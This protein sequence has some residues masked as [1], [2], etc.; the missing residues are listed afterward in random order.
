MINGLS[1]R[2]GSG[3]SYEAVVTHIL[4]ALKQGRKIVTNIPLNV[5]WFAA[6]LGEEVRELIEIVDGGFHNYGALRY[7]SNA[8]DFLKYQDW[9]NEKNQG[10]YFFVDECHLSMPKLTAANGVER[11]KQQT[12]L[13]EYLS[14]HRHYGHDLLLLTQNFRKVDPDIRDMVSTCYF[15]TKLSFLGQDHKYVCKVADGVT[16]NIVAKHERQYEKKYF[17]A[18]KSHTKSEGSVQEAKTADVK[19]WWQHNFMIAG[20]CMLVLFLFLAYR[21]QQSF[22]EGQ[23]KRDASIQKGKQAFSQANLSRENNQPVSQ[24]NLPRENN[25]PVSQANLSREN[26]QSVSQAN[27]SRE[28]NQPVSQAKKLHP[29]SGLQMHLLGTAQ[30][31][32]NRGKYQ[33]IIWIAV[34]RNGQMLKEITHADLALAGYQMTVLNDCMIDLSFGDVWQ[35]YIFC[36]SPTQEVSFQNTPAI[37]KN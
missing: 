27:L 30:D 12:E 26:N 10:V 29:Y 20:V 2:P 24:A 15:T 18:Y 31:F 23:A 5:D 3:K 14:M 25:Q 1:G 35:D 33:K 6:V 16:R 7:F 22:A 37:A 34:S 4:P 19:P 28:N 17:A 8:N 36:D 9:R 11:I 13:K 21:T 32:D